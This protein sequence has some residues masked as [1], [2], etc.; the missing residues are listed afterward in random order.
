MHKETE[1][2]HTVAQVHA[3]ALDKSL[4]PQTLDTVADLFGAVGVSFELVKK[5]NNR[6]FY[7]DLSDRFGAIPH[8]EYLDYY[9]GINVRLPH[10]LKQPT[11][12]LDFD[13][14]FL[15]EAD[16]DVNEFY[17]DFLSRYDL[18]YFLSG[19]VLNSDTYSGVLSVHRS[20]AQGHVEDDDLNL[21][22]LFL[23]HMQQA[24][25]T[26]F[27]LEQA[28]ASGTLL[29]SGLDAIGEAV[30]LLD[31]TGAVLHTNNV[32][33]DIFALD[34]GIIVRRGCLEFSDRNATDNLGDALCSSGSPTRNLA[35]RR[36]S[37]RRPYLISIRSLP[38]RD[39]LGEGL[40]TAT[41]ILFIRDPETF[42]GLDKFLLQQSYGLSPAE[43]ELAIALDRGL[44]V[45]GAA[46]QRDVSIT[47]MRGHLYA[48]MSK[49]RVTRQADLTR[50]LRQYRL[51][52]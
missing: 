4:W 11:G 31:E 37:G 38:P 1:L 27:R 28:S 12:G 44:T 13:H 35:A 9:G 50:L 7:L 17:S 8:Q 24:I 25:D 45:R 33:E 23:P 19:N 52:F 20:S 2:L 47:T 34:D 18:R 40:G 10:I 21:M 32:A 48:L 3:A 6:P 16:I 22:R 30:I 49:M 14:A 42:S 29:L 26:R 51:P 46:K 39:I 5:R 41:A 36:P 15:S 43:T